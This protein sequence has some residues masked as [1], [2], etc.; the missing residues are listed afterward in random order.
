MTDSHFTKREL[1]IVNFI[2]LEVEPMRAKPCENSI[3]VVPADEHSSTEPVLHLHLDAI[4]AAKRP[5]GAAAPS[6]AG[7]VGVGNARYAPYRISR[8]AAEHL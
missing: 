4:G 1:L 5:W 2:S 8:K 3:A 6:D 7:P